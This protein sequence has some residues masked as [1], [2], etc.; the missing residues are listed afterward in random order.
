MRYMSP[1]S[2]N[3]VDEDVTEISIVS[4]ESRTSFTGLHCST[5]SVIAK[6]VNQGK[7]QK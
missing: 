3:S 6:R 1:D 4:P 7:H 5:I 2:R